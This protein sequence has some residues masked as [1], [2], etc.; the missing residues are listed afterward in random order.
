MKWINEFITNSRT[1]RFNYSLLNDLNCE[2]FIKRDDLIHPEISGNKIRKLLYNLKFCADN[3]IQ[4]IV[5]YGGAFSNHLLA[6][7]SAANLSD[8][9]AIG[10]V[11][12]D[13][14]NQH[15][16]DVLKRCHELGMKLEFI[17]RVTFSSQ[18]H[19][20]GIIEIEGKPFL[21]IPEGGANELGVFGC[22][23][24]I[25]ELPFE[26]DYYCL[27]QGTTTTSIGLATAL[28]KN[29]KLIVVPVLKGFDSKTEMRA[30]IGDVN[31]NMFEQNLVILDDYHFGGYAK[32]TVELKS[33]IS[34]F[35]NQNSFEIEP[36]YT[37]K[38][39]Y[40]L[41]QFLISNN[42]RNKKVLFVHTGGLSNW[43][44]KTII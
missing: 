22:Q 8:I 39:M 40:A 5:T 28:P 20:S 21:S 35:N 17:D 13:E 23:G 18:K 37:G 7:A 41:V 11:R 9:Q 27:A 38:A 1:E 10:R 6:T 16:N 12:G 42:I 44:S 25:S 32:D 34:E 2:L 24:L 19:F 3:D 26:F 33:F 29:S 30:I 15:S 43:K 4:G 31:F 14:L 36:V